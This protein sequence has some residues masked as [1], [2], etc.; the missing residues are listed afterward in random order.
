MQ[1]PISSPATLP[2]RAAIEGRDVGAALDAFAE[3]ALLRSPLTNRVAFH[4]REQIGAVMEILLERFH[5]ITYTDE[6]RGEHTGFLVARA[7]V[8]GQQIELVDHMLLDA[9]GR[10]REMTVFF[11]PLPAAATTL[12]TFGGGLGRRRSASRGAFVSALARPLG[13]MARAGD[14]LGA[15]L[16]R[17]SL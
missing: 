8:D 2:L 12:S 11:R 13:L 15:R 6:L 7:E 3:D 16:I 5:G 17:G 1:A 14:A 9:D 10:I 4:G